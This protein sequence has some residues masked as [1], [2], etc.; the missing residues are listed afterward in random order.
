MVCPVCQAKVVSGKGVRIPENDTR[1]QPYL[2]TSISSGM[3]YFCFSHFSESDLKKNEFGR[4]RPVVEFPE[5]IGEELPRA[6]HPAITPTRTYIRKAIPRDVT[7]SQSINSQAW[8]LE[9]EREKDVMMFGDSKNAQ[10]F[11]IEQKQ[12]ALLLSSCFDCSAKIQSHHLSTV[13]TNVLAKFNCTN[14][15]TRK[16]WSGQSLVGETTQHTAQLGGERKFEPVR[17]IFSKA[18]NADVQK[19]VMS[20]EDIKWKR[21]AA[22]FVV[23]KRSQIRVEGV[24]LANADLYDGFD[25]DEYESFSSG[26][27]SDQGNYFNSDVD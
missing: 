25:W 12:L 1:L 15:K 4:G 26:E 3:P 16:F 21:R 27:E 9:E 2:A 18:K 6:S 17:E 7:E 14:C 24:P 19:K 23:L 20:K 5:D 11:I 13:A 10:F 8:D 22:D